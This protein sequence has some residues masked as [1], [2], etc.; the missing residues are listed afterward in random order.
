MENSK[1]GNGK[2]SESINP[3][4]ECGNGIIEKK[5][6]CDDGNTENGDGC[7]SACIIEQGFVC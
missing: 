3:K 5:E 2:N 4:T 1:D 7:D 6:Q